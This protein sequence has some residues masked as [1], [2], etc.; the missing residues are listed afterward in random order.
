MVARGNTGSAS[1]SYRST[2]DK[3]TLTRYGRRQR[4]ATRVVSFIVD[5]IDVVA[6][7][8]ADLYFDSSSSAGS[9]RRRVEFRRIV[10]LDNRIVNAK[11]NQV[12][13]LLVWSVRTL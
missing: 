4:K 8:L 5:A 13:Y 7:E 6:R 9:K 1:C 11:R 10:V 12:D 2:A 3:Q